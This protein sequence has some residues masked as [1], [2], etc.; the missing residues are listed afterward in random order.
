MILMIL[1]Y[2]GFITNSADD[3]RI[4]IKPSS[5]V[6]IVSNLQFQRF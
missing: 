5:I 4:A 6:I 1:K 3:T 2:I